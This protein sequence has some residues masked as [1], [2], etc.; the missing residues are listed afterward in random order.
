MK[1]VLLILGLGIGCAYAEQASAPAAETSHCQEILAAGYYHEGVEAV[2]GLESHV[3]DALHAHYQATGCEA[4]IDEAA[5]AE[6][7][8]KTLNDANLRYQTLGKTEFCGD[9]NRAA[10]PTLQDLVT[11]DK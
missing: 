3:S 6:T 10:Y 5:L 4:V 11:K 1:K 7:I 8:G 2:C 9:A